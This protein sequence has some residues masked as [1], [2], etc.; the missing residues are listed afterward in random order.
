MVDAAA[1]LQAQQIVGQSEVDSLRQIYGDSN[2]R[3]RAAQA[4]VGELGRQLEKMSGSAAPLTTGSQPGD[5]PGALYPPLR[6]LPRLGVMY[7]DLYRRVR[8]QEQVFELLTQQDEMARIAEARD[9]PVV[10][11]IDVPGIAEKKS[12]PPRVLVTLLIML[13]IVSCAAVA[14][15][16]RERWDRLEASDPRRVLGEEV[17]QAVRIGARRWRT[18]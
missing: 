11:V 12:F 10:S 14:L 4:R 18:R 6:Q 16:A 17:A 7:V 2:V 13:L 9:I 15:L 5:A 8:V 1:R 3:V